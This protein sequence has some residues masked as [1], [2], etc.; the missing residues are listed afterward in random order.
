MGPARP[1]R[2]GMG[3]VQLFEIVL[4]HGRA[5]YSPGEPLAGAVRVRL[6]APLPFRGGRHCCGPGLAPSRRPGVLRG[7]LSRRAA[8]LPGPGLACPRSPVSRSTRSLAGS[9]EGAGAALE[10]PW[11]GC[12]R[13]CGPL[14]GPWLPQPPRALLKPTLG[15]PALGRKDTVPQR[16]CAA[17]HP[18]PSSWVE[19]EF[20]EGEGLPVAVLGWS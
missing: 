16:G 1:A 17:T 4:R 9:R 18:F 8:H 6:G 15:C 20:L 10:G 11:Q 19:F 5:V 13:C 3:R 7:L 2:R 12:R 14:A